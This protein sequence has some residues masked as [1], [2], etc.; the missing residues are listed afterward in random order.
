MSISA[1]EANC[2]GNVS[3]TYKVPSLALLKC[4]LYVLLLNSRGDIVLTDIKA[5][6]C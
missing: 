6:S 5:N 4:A 2:A 1:V 3:K